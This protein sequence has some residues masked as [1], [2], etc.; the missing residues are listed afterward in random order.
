MILRTYTIKKKRSEQPI[1]NI[2][3]VDEQKEKRDTLR[4][5]GIDLNTSDDVLSKTKVENVYSLID[6]LSSNNVETEYS[7]LDLINDR[8]KEKY[9]AVDNI[10]QILKTDYELS[11]NEP[12]DIEV[13][14]SIECN[15]DEEEEVVR[16]IESFPNFSKWV[17][18]IILMENTNTAVPDIK[19]F[20]IGKYLVLCDKNNESHFDYI[21]NHPEYEGEVENQHDDCISIYQLKILE[22]KYTNNDIQSAFSKL[23]DPENSDVVS[24][25]EKINFLNKNVNASDGFTYVDN[26]NIVNTQELENNVNDLF[27]KIL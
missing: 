15:L 14:Q 16:K 7:M 10:N 6:A 23:Y 26:S 3:Q 24:I 5:Y 20:K 4:D 11:L 25:D 17:D 9:K 13:F 2:I 12:K 22:T 1:L 18:R 21:K 8:I 19:T 27:S